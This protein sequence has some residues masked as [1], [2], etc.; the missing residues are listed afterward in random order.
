MANLWRLRVVPVARLLL[1]SVGVILSFGGSTACPLIAIRGPNFSHPLLMILSSAAMVSSWA[2]EAWLTSI[3][4]F[5]IGWSVSS[6]VVRLPSSCA[7]LF[8]LVAGSLL[9]RPRFFLIVLFP[10]FLSLTYPIISGTSCQACC[11]LVAGSFLFFLGQ[12]ACP[13]HCRSYRDEILAV[14]P[15][16]RGSRYCYHRYLSDFLDRLTPDPKLRGQ[17]FKGTRV[18]LTLDQGSS[19]ILTHMH[20][21]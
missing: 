20:L 14:W 12:A 4:N 16:Q 2:G 8:L 18:P 6:Q 10:Y 3:V 19:F 17:T 11:S 15:S 9:E 1:S 13:N 21:L 5:F 7:Y